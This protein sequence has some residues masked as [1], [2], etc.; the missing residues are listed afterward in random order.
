[1]KKESVR[2]SSVRISYFFNGPML[3]ANMAIKEEEVR[4]AELS[5][6]SL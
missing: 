5:L 6:N 3:F 4:Q 1:V 2:H